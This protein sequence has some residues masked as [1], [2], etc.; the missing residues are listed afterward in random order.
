MDDRIKVRYRNNREGFVD[1]VTLNELIISKKIKQFYRPSEKRWVNIETDP[2]RRE[3]RFFN[4]SERRR[5]GV[6]GGACREMMSRYFGRR[7]PDRRTAQ[8]W[9]EKGFDLLFTCGQY[10]AATRAFAQAIRMD[11]CNARAFLDRG[12]AYEKMGNVEQA[13]ADYDQAIRLSPEDAK[14]YYIRGLTH[15]RLGKYEEAAQDLALA[16]DL[17]YRQAHDT[18]KSRASSRPPRPKD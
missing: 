18:L 17:G 3:K 1:D 14:A 10:E 4:G 16:A 11:P 8:E 2:V 13:L 12:M 7:S 9:F 15:Q 5:K 6:L